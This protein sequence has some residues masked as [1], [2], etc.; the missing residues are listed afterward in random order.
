MFSFHANTL[1]CKGF[2]AFKR[3][4]SFWKSVLSRI[5]IRIFELFLFFHDL[6]VQHP[7]LFLGQRA[8]INTDCLLRKFIYFSLVFRLCGGLLLFS[9]LCCLRDSYRLFVILGCLE[10]E[11]DICLYATDLVIRFTVY[12]INQVIATCKL[13]TNCISFMQHRVISQ[14]VLKAKRFVNISTK[15]TLL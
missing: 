3:P 14:F 13:N 12:H 5:E 2:H 7:L 4:D 6:C 10:I 15:L 9:L 11:V 1:S 8:S